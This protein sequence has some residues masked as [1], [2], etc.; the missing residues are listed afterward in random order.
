M[1]AIN[2]PSH[3]I[4]V[5]T[6]VQQTLARCVDLDQIRE[7]R[8]QAE[9]VRHYIKTA[10]MGLEMQNRAG[11]VK[12]RCERRAGAILRTLLVQ[13]GDRKSKH[14][15]PKMT[16]SELGITKTQSARWQLEATLP[17]DDFIEFV[18]R[19]NRERRELT[20]SRLLWLAR[21][22]AETSEPET[23]SAS[24]CS[25]LSKFLINRARQGAQF[26]CIY[27]EPPWTVGKQRTIA[28][29][30]RRLC[31]L[32]VKL[33]AAPQA[34]V[35]LCVP[36]RLLNAGFSVLRAWGFR[37][38]S[39]LVRHR[40]PG[41]Y[42]SYWRETFDVVLLGVRGRLPFR[43]NSLTSWVEGTDRSVTGLHAL[44]ERASPPPY[45][46]LFGRAAPE[47]WTSVDF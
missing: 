17:E 16:L 29:L 20:S 38:R 21:L 14:R 26:A 34:H 23:D 9:A 41:D 43:D 6:G 24:V 7:L 4:T 46:D 18:E 1:T 33:V 31:S 47:G 30:P 32:P 22:C 27:A 37:Y 5:L 19:M 10:S 42:G 25:R 3:A 36:P 39:A 12:L 15:D 8:N 45:L 28:Y 35:H 13:G 11:E 44:L 40:P 2:S